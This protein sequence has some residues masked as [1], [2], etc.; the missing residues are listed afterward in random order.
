MFLSSCLV[1]FVVLSPFHT[2]STCTAF[3]RINFFT[4]DLF[5]VA[6]ET[7]AISRVDCP[8]GG[9][10]TLCFDRQRV[11]VTRVCTVTHEERSSRTEAQS[12]LGVSGWQLGHV[13][14]TVVQ[15][16]TVVNEPLN[17]M[18]WRMY[19]LYTPSDARVTVRHRLSSIWRRR[20]GGR[21]GRRL[22]TFGCWRP[23][24]RVISTRL[25]ATSGVRGLRLR[26]AR[27]IR[28][29][30]GACSDKA[31]CNAHLSAFRRVYLDTPSLWMI[32]RWTAR[33]DGRRRRTSGDDWT[34]QRRRG[35]GGFLDIGRTARLSLFIHGMML[36]ARWFK[37]DWRCWSV[38]YQTITFSS[39]ESIVG[40]THRAA[41]RSLAVSQ[42]WCPSWSL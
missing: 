23:T 15:L 17:V 1:F 13:E 36:C 30:G 11:E 18:L 38:V 12:A 21:G 35:L 8:D 33:Y 27:S 29:R 16:T 20:R 25:L 31:R 3:M 10:S 39:G 24:A 7:E 2:S 28:S 41:V 14:L 4:T 37:H 26:L 6:V 19:R 5:W 9:D 32:W 34:S 22:F 40:R 42:L